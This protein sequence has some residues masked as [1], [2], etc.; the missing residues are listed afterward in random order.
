MEALPADS[1]ATGDQLNF[2]SFL[3]PETRELGQGFQLSN[4]RVDSMVARSYPPRYYQQSPYSYKRHLP[5]TPRVIGIV[6]QG[7]RIKNKYA[8]QTIILQK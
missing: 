4:P 1:M 6:C 2:Q 3:F 7:V 5:E 8:L